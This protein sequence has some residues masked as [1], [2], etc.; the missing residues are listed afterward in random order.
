[1]T[2]W[3][4]V[5]GLGLGL[6]RTYR[7]DNSLLHSQTYMMKNAFIQ[8]PEYSFRGVKVGSILGQKLRHAT[9]NNNPSPIC[10][11]CLAVETQDLFLQQSPGS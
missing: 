1:M 10:D 11:D 6:V 7:D 2:I 4:S 5:A 8:P 3:K 9:L